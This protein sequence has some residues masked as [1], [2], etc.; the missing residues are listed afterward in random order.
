MDGLTGDRYEYFNRYPLPF[1]VLSR[2][3]LQPFSSDAASWLYAARQWMN[4]IFIAT[5][6][7][8]WGLLRT[9]RFSRVVAIASILLTL[10][11][12]VVLEYRSMFHFDQPALLAY[13]VLL[14]V[15]VRQLI[16]PSPN[17]RWYLGVLL[18]GAMTGRSAVV[19]IFSLVLPL[20]LLV[21]KPSPFDG[22]SQAGA[23]A[24]PWVWLGVPLAFGA[25]FVATAYNV[26]W[27]ARLNQV[28]WQSTSVVQ[29]AL[30]RLG[31]V[32]IPGSAVERTRWL[33]GAI[34]K[35]ASYLSEYLSP[36][37]IV[38][39][40]LIL[41]CLIMSRLGYSASAFNVAPVDSLSTEK[42]QLRHSMLWSTG[43]TSLLWIVVMKNLF[44]FHIYAGMVILPF[45]LLGM[46]LVLEALIAQMNV[47]GIATP[48]QIDRGFVVASCSVFLIVLFFGPGAQ[49]RPDGPRR[50]ELEGFFAELNQYRNGLRAGDMVWRDSE[51]FP[52]SPTAQCALLDV[53]LLVGEHPEGIKTSEPPPFPERP[54]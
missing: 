48:R 15:V 34:P 53:P 43:L 10:S 31:F 36:L 47:V 35:L 52:R 49:L 20:L 17:L 24:L 29:S 6:F 26:V 32:D 1:A 45:L 13:G 5:G 9:L 21:L 30:R 19:L 25:V 4:L 41:I 40:L 46:A 51:W 27:E 11:A 37:L 23:R 14:V 7:A 18:L 28:S 44:V 39:A 8:F 42:Y 2:L 38:V 50:V 54:R 33:G 22:E 3:V 16:K 12:P